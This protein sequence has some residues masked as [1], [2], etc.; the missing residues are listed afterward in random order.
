M[1]HFHRI[2]NHCLL[3]LS[4]FFA[5]A[6]TAS[7][8][9]SQD[10]QT[11]RCLQLGALWSTS[12]SAYYEGSQS[13]GVPIIDLTHDDFYWKTTTVGY[14]L[15]GEESESTYW[16]IA[17]QLSLPQDGLSVENQKH[18]E[19]LSDRDPPLEGGLAFVTSTHLGNLEI[20]VNADLEDT[21]KGVSAEALYSYRI[22]SGNW[23][24]TP[25]LTLHY[26]DEKN[27]NYYYGLS[28][29]E[30]EQSTLHAY[31]IHDPTLSVSLGYR[32]NQKLTGKWRLFHSFGHRFLD[33]SIKQSPLT[34]S[35]TG[36]VVTLG[37]L[38]QVY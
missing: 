36:Y 17:G 33:D 8:C 2:R 15:L 35:D 1:T 7:A 25:S 32:F 27:A 28:A 26:R 19:G 3:V 5:L 13:A 4:L 24:F 34:V 21:H 31:D 6:S 14:F 11:N 12:E 23:A 30:A 37:V 29:A 9:Q 16:A 18:L 20:T 10:S 38:Y 22:S